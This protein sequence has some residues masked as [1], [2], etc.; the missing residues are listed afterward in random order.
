MKSKSSLILEGLLHDRLN[1]RYE[2]DLGVS[3]EDIPTVRDS[4]KMQKLISQALT[5][6][7]QKVF[8]EFGGM[9]VDVDIYTS[10]DETTYVEDAVQT[11]GMS[12]IFDADVKDK[13]R[14]IQFLIKKFM[15]NYPD[16]KYEKSD[17][18][19]WFEAESYE[20]IIDVF[21]TIQHTDRVNLGNGYRVVDASQAED[22][23]RRQNKEWQDEKDSL[24][25]EY[26]RSRL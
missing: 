2:A 15:K 10:D 13:V 18:S 23:Y 19:F 22:D 9:G 25:R 20:D 12:L 24:Q 17:N 16:F 26:N 8:A 11:F 6:K 21:D 1:E 3:F 14:P 5:A 4:R 7:Y